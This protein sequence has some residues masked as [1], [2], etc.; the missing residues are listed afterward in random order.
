MS[1]FDTDSTAEETSTEAVD[2]PAEE[3]GEETPSDAV[4]SP[5]EGSVAEEAACAPAGPGWKRVVKRIFIGIGV[6]VVGLI[7]L[8]ALL[9]QFGGMW[10]RTPEMKTAYKDMVAAGTAEPVN[11]RFTIPIPGCTCH[12]DDPVLQAKHSVRHVKDCMKCH[13][14]DPPHEEPGVQ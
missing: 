2:P 6:T 12:S 7:V 3:T 10:V 4:D 1:D 8:A 11:Y 5:V 13:N 9:Y 14:T